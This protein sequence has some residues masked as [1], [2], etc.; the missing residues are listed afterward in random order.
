MQD[1]SR[2]CNLKTEYEELSSSMNVSTMRTHLT[3]EN[4]LWFLEAG[5]R[6]NSKF[7]NFDRVV[8]ICR[9]YVEELARVK[10]GNYN[11]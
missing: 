8:A 2:I 7:K 3:V 5:R 10:Y 11:E 4:A 6:F 1:I 9:E